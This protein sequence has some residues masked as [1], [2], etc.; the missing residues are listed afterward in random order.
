M[1]YNG[2]YILNIDGTNQVVLGNTNAGYDLSF[3]NNLG[4]GTSSTSNYSY[5]IS[6]F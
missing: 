2:N 3:S 4:I 6:I 5:I 1:Q